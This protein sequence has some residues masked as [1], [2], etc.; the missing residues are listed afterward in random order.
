[1]S[2][3]GLDKR[4][5][6]KLKGLSKII[7]VFAK[8][9]RICLYVAL[10][11][12]VL[13]M[14]CMPILIKNTTVSE[15]SL[16]FEYK[17]DKIS[18]IEKEG[19]LEIYHNDEKM[20]S[21]SED[22]KGY[23]TYRKAFDKYSKKQLIGYIEAGFIFIIT[24]LILILLILKHLGKLFKNIHQGLTPFT[25]DNVEHMRMMSIYMIS[26]IVLPMIASVLY[27][28]CAEIDINVSFGIIDIVEILFVL[29]M[30]FVFKYGYSLQSESKTTIYDE[31]E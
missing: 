31:E 22:M 20:K 13:A 29:S 14:I 12:I 23:K 9:G 1:M 8:I 3:V 26:A 2:K 21:T 16:I 30:S 17:N 24:Y 19:K 10:P 7:A 28:L 6:N 15:S 27:Q 11:F 25:L 18:M 4:S 5:Q